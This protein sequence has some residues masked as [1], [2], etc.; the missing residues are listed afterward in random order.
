MRALVTGANGFVGGW[1]VRELQ[2]RGA[3]VVGTSLT[4][5]P[6]DA[7]AP[8]AALGIEWLTC[9]VRERADVA[10]ALDAARPDAVFH[11]AGIAAAPVA[12]REPGLALATNVTS[13]LH[14]VDVVRERREA[15]VLDPVCLVIGS[16][17]QY[18]RHD[19]RQLP[20]PESAELRPHS[21]YAATKVAQEVVALQAH[22]TSGVRVVCTRA[23]NHTGRGQA[24]AFL[25]PALVSRALGLRGSARPQL[26]MGNQH[27]VR[28][29]LHVEDVAR[30]Y[31]L[32]AER[33]AT[34]EVYNVSSGTGTSIGGLARRVLARVGVA[35]ELAS[36]PALQRPA[37]VPALTGDSTRLRAL[38]W[39]PEY[40]LD[41][42]I[43]DLIN[44]ATH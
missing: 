25:V 1:V 18:G 16:G 27:P 30:A 10:R 32:L 34:G 20:L 5:A 33:G 21:V 44:A 38:G 23:F 35:A 36:D 28:D 26:V 37:D 42:I 19:D 14:L 7:A 22:R 24:A 6:A 29:F 8:G 39:S 11:L 9:D 43:D 12:A 13:T 15:G 2:R 4:G 40:D 41:A 17:E 31:V 3:T